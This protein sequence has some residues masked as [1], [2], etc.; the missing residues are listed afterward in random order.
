[1]S[2]RGVVAVGR[3]VSQKTILDNIELFGPESARVDL[4]IRW[5]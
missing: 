1:M 5:R 4:G 2:Q 3:T